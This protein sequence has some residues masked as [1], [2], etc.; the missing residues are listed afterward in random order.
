MLIIS[1]EMFLWAEFILVQFFLYP[2]LSKCKWIDNFLSLIL[3]VI[4]HNFTRAKCEFQSV[5]HWEHD[6]GDPLSQ[7]SSTKEKFVPKSVPPK[8]YQ[9]TLD[10][11]LYLMANDAFNDCSLSLFFRISMCSITMFVGIRHESAS[12]MTA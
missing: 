12:F 9:S 8:S 10:E 7:W 4:G 1:F 2:R 6:C 3:N 11:H 5:L